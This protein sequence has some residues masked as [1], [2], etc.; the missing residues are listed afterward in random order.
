MAQKGD[1]IDIKNTILNANKLPETV[2]FDVIES[3]KNN[4]TKFKI[5]GRS[6][7]GAV[8]L[9]DDQTRK[10]KVGISSPA[11]KELS[12]PLIES[13][14]YIKRALEPFADI[15]INEIGALIKDDM[16]VIIMPDIAAMPA[17]ILNDLEKWVANGGL[18]LRFAGVNMAK[19]QSEQF[20]LPVILRSG[21]RAL[22]GTLS[23]EDEQNIADFPEDS[24]LYGL[25]I[26]DDIT[27]KQY[28]L[29]DPAQ[30]LDGKI[31]ASLSDGTPFITAKPHGKGLITLIH[32]SANTSWS[33]FALSGL[34][35]SV[36]KR[37]TS[38][39][40]LS[41]ITSNSSYKSLDPLLVMDGYGAMISP[42]ASVKPIPADSLSEITPSSIHPAGLYGH[43]KMRYALNIGTNL[44]ALKATQNLPYSIKQSYYD[45]E[46]E[47]N[48]MP[49]LLYAA[50]ILFLLDW[51]I[52]IFIAG[53]GFRLASFV[54]SLSIL[55][56]IS[57]ANSDMDIKLA[58]GFHLAYIET[59]DDKVD[60]TSLRGLKGLSEILANRTSVEPVGVIGINP[61][62]DIMAFYPL[63]Y[64][65]I[66][67]NQKQLSSKAMANIQNYLDHGGTILFDTRDQ[68]RSTGSVMNTPNAKT[69]RS[70][71]ASLNIPP[72]IPIPKG[73]VLGRAFYLLDEYVGQ[74]SAGTLWVEQQSAS[75]RDNVSSVIIG[76]NDWAAAWSG[77]GSS[78]GSNNNRYLSRQREMSLRF[79]VNLVMYALTGNY[80]ADQV[81]ISH[82]LKRL[83]K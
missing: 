10:R 40:G 4:I 53:K 73:H 80:K 15:T 39:A 52:M 45:K 16:A 44:P 58:D 65:A 21:G 43:G 66:G 60:N 71:T 36:L 57:F 25:D 56:C 51:I 35:V 59:G 67:E 81:H 11:Q 49:F 37:I 70:I 30:D 9:L 31:W 8:F 38:L 78:A 3:L 6:G 12:A 41:N 42:P 82:I 32:T 29:A 55:P 72:I 23:W 47:L 69:L 2:E 13:S 61:E 33:D 27:I 7:A 63:I 46:Y 54:I 64:W 28:I 48:I 50:L 62:S 26:P 24:P 77:F 5:S 18:L 68:N 17:Q 76:S 14:Y 22:S 34:Y 83:G 19:A 74:Y 75:G 20:L 79:G 1:I